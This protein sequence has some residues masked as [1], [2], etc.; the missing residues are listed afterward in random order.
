MYNIYENANESR[1]GMNIL[2]T[3][4]E[5]ISLY[6]YLY[7]YGRFARALLFVVNISIEKFAELFVRIGFPDINLIE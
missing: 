3:K 7:I 6:K 2:N 1:C 4:M 5:N